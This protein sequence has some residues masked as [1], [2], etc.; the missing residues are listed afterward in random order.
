MNARV[1]R[2]LAALC[3][4]MSLGVPGGSAQVH[5]G[6]GSAPTTNA[7]GGKG[8]GDYVA[9]SFT[10]DQLYGLHRFP[11]P[12]VTAEQAKTIKMKQIDI[13]T[14]QQLSP[15]MLSEAKKKIDAASYEGS[16]LTQANQ[17]VDKVA[18]QVGKLVDSA[19]PT[20]SPTSSSAAT[21]SKIL[22]ESLRG[23]GEDVIGD[24]FALPA[25]VGCAAS[26]LT[27]S[28]ASDIF[29]VRVANKYV[30]VQV[31]VRNLNK[32]KDFLLHDVELAVDD[33]DLPVG[34][35]PAKFESGRDRT[36]VRAVSLRNQ[37]DDTRNFAVRVLEEWAPWLRRRSASVQPIMRGV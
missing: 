15:E 37:S 30:A 17:T 10:P 8:M 27:Y 34:A 9:C 22:V 28:E 23:A 33:P 31:V 5:G 35:A 2:A 36:L 19:F 29:G 32:D 26:V 16:S 24:P 14:Q 21:D 7:I 6:A 12:Q 25:D 1:Q 11:R 13:V 3:L 20:G 4:G 18:N